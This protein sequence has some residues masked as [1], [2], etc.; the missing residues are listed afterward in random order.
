MK[1]N[2]F[3]LTICF[4]IIA[5]F[6][7]CFAETST[8]TTQSLPVLP[9]SSP[10]SFI[11]RPFSGYNNTYCPY[12]YNRTPFFNTENTTSTTTNSDGTQKI[13]TT[14]PNW[15]YPYRRYN[16]Y[17]SRRYYQPYPYSY[18]PTTTSTGTNIVRSIF[19]W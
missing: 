13:V 4:T 16:P 15:N 6:E 11:Q 2:I 12:D 10:W 9:V 8:V 7:I 19:G 17:F 5:L 14:T 3:A 18:Q 1:K